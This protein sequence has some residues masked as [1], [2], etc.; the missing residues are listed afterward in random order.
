MGLKI[1]GYFAGANSEKGFVNC[2]DRAVEGIERLYILKGSSGCGKSSFMKKIAAAAEE[3]GEWAERIYCSSDVASLDGVVLRE[4]SVAVLDGTAPHAAELRYPG[5]RDKFINLGEFWDRAKLI[6]RRDEVISLSD[7]KK[8]CFSAAYRMLR[9]VGELR[10]ERER[11]TDKALLH[12]KLG[13][14][15]HRVIK[16]NSDE[17]KGF[18]LAVRLNTAFCAEGLCKTELCEAKKRYVILDSHDLA[19]RALNALLFEA[20]ERKLAVTVSL[21]P[22]SPRRLNALLLNESGV[23]FELGEIGE[24]DKQI[25]LERF[26][27]NAILA[28]NRGRER[29]TARCQKVLTEGARE[30][31]EEARKAHLSLEDI[32]VPAM[33][34]GAVD[35]CTRLTVK[36]IFG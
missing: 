26:I 15:A 11:L 21:D 23:L 34:F 28:Q 14:F 36:E 7:K 10:D 31:L 8:E 6:P 17:G 24:G 9:A 30:H 35:Q 18:S 32:Y 25:N 5:V 19:G 33:D 22:L 13:D 16:A 12:K 3:R 4:R 1:K 27:D 2:F 20:R 29:F